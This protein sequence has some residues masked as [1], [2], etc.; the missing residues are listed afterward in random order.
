MNDSL[1]RQQ[2][3]WEGVFS[4]TPEFFGTEPSTPARNAAEL[5]VRGKAARIL[6]LG[7]GQG[8]DTLYFALR[9]LNVTVLDYARQGIAAIRHKAEGMDLASRVQALQHDIRLPLPFAPGQFDGCFSHMLYCMALT[10]E[11]L[12]AL[13]REVRR[14]LK[15]GGHQIYT[16]RHT[17]DAH[18]GKGVHRGEAIYET[19]GFAVHFFSREKV[20]RL[21]EGF[22]IL[23][24]DE[25][26][27]G[28]L[29]RKL[30]QVTL[31]KPADW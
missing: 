9:G 16:V 26:E 7:G 1:H 30:F 27:E 11:E 20:A 2:G 17:G 12:T 29:P 14:V 31:R 10:T 5:F 22:E 6:E 18:F 25:F 24:I 8:R 4:E 3:Q 19:G 28:A 23:G 15:P 13:S 21:A